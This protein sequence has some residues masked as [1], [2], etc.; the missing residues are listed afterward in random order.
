MLR[1]KEAE[2][3]VQVVRPYPV[4]YLYKYRSMTSKGVKDVFRKREIFLTDA[5]RF[6]DPFE[7]RPVLTSHQSSL[8]R[9]IYLK[10]LTKERFPNADKRTLKKLM[11]GKGRLLTDQATLRR[12]Y[13][14]FI[15]TVGIYCLAERNDD[16]LMWAHYSDSHRGLCLGFDASPVGTLFWEAFKVV[17]QVEYP[18][19]NLMAMDCGDEFRKAILTKST[20]WIY[21]QERRIVKMEDEGGSGFYT[22]SPHLLSSVIFGALMSSQDKETVMNWIRAFPTRIALYQARLNEHKYQLDIV[23]A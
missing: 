15:K 18:T 2:K 19:V 8:K 23:P 5:T 9:E 14:D 6:N 10:Q 21:E 1:R 13:D 11:K 3:L 17:Y 16:L 7:C 22:F 12:T 4:E 20:H